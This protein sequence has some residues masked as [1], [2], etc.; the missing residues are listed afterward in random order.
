MTRVGKILVATIV[1]LSVVCLSNV[2][3]AKET[4]YSLKGQVVSIDPL[5]QTLTVQSIEK[6]PALISGTLGEF[7]FSMDEMTKITMC[8]QTKS[9]GDIKVGQ[10]VTVGYHGHGRQLYADS[11]AVPAPLMACLIE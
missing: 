3:F 5:A 7:M 11:I 9:V 4:E 1:V 2:T 8:N 6:I 10:E